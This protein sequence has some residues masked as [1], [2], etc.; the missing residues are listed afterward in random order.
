MA[1]GDH[2]MVKRWHGLYYHHGIDTGDEMVIHLAGEPLRSRQAKV[3]R[4]P[5]EEFLRN[6]KKIIVKYSDDIPL[7]APAETVAKAEEL[8][9]QNGYSLTGKNCEHFATYCKTG[10]AASE[11]VKFYVRL[12]S[13]V[14][15]A[16]ATAV[17]LMAGARLLKR[18]KRRRDA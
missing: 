6:G 14:V 9:E 11:Q 15:L 13:V 16:G 10:R 4:T 3:C 12:G 17:A 1:V 5:L 7:L 8:L 18:M 2:I